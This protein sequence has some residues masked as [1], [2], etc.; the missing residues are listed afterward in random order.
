MGAHLP[1]VFERPP[2]RWRVT[3]LQCHT[4]KDF[5]AYFVPLT[6]NLSAIQ[7]QS[8]IVS[9][10]NKA[11]GT[12]SYRRTSGMPYSTMISIAPKYSVRSLDSPTA[13]DRRLKATHRN[14]R[15]SVTILIGADAAVNTGIAVIAAV[16]TVMV[17]QRKTNPSVLRRDTFS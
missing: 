2:L 7:S 17:Y 5:M 16:I 1:L 12:A 11:I 9:P 13:L 14:T 6:P 8:R 10:R 4:Y 3:Q 15:P